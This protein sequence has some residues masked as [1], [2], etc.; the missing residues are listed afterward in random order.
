MPVRLIIEYCVANA[1]VQ[2]IISLYP[3]NLIGQQVLLTLKRVLMN[4]RERIAIFLGQVITGNY[5]FQPISQSAMRE[6]GI[7]NKH[8]CSS[9]VLRIQSELFKYVQFRLMNITSIKNNSNFL[10]NDFIAKRLI[11]LSKVFILR[12]IIFVYSPNALKYFSISFTLPSFL[13]S[14]L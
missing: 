9:I 14:R 11:L 5:C 8:K 13:H 7:Y 3:V 6:F 1:V 12:Q 4:D 10:P 2:F